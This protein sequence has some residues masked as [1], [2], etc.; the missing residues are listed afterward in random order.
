VLLC[1]QGQPRGGAVWPAC[2]RTF[3]RRGDGRACLDGPM[4]GVG[5]AGGLG[6]TAFFLAIQ[7][8]DTSFL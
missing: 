6:Q 8:V 4:Y 5:S 1:A 3:G 7:V 2:R